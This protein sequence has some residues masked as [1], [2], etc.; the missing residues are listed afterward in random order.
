MAPRT[1]VLWPQLFPEGLSNNEIVLHARLDRIFAM[2]LIY[3]D[4]LDKLFSQVD[5]LSKKFAAAKV[6]DPPS[7]ALLEDLKKML[8]QWTENPDAGG[9]DPFFDDVNGRQQ[10]EADGFRQP[11]LVDALRELKTRTGAFFIRKPAATTKLGCIE[12]HKNFAEREAP[13]L[14]FV[15][16]IYRQVGRW[17]S[18]SP[19]HTLIFTLKMPLSTASSQSSKMSKKRAQKHIKSEKDVYFLLRHVKEITTNLDR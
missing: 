13:A 2:Q 14:T 5:V 8:D 15:C 16:W 1:K 12:V 4:R 10:D 6:L 11:K 19:F 17:T 7:P 18:Q 9:P 3:Q